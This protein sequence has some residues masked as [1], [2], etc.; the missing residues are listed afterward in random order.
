MIEERRLHDVKEAER[1]I[2]KCGLSVNYNVDYT[3]GLFYDDELIATGS[4]C[5]DMLQMVAVAPDHQGEDLASVVVTHL[6]KHAMETG[7]NNLCLFTKPEKV[8]MFVPLGF[9]IVAIAKPYAALLEWGRPGIQEYV[10][11]I[12]AKAKDFD[13]GSSA[14]VMNCNPFTLGHL[15]LIET[16]ASKSS[17]VF[18]LAVQEDISAFPFDVRY[19]LICDGTSHLPNVT[20]IPGGRYVVSSLTFPSYFTKDTELANAH[21]AIDVEIFLKHVVPALGITRRYIG[22]EPFSPV[23]EIYNKTMKERLIP[24]GVEVVEIP[25]IEKSGMAISASRVR[26]LLSQGNIEDVKELVPESTY[27]YLISESAAPVLDKLKRVKD[28]IGFLPNSKHLV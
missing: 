20:V 28:S 11:D 22:T 7:K 26:S 2:Q 14:I 17:R 21:S 3:V 24:A 13:G 15:Y 10:R 1:L 23:T 16:A 19:K 12:K 27:N 8:N 9:N 25:R 5:G 6:I 18:I 4:L